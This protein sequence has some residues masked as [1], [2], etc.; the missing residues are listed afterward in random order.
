MRSG[1]GELSARR[2]KWGESD[3]TPS[4][5]PI[6]GHSETTVELAA[7]PVNAQVENPVTTNSIAKRTVNVSGTQKR[8]KCPAA[9]EVTYHLEVIVSP[10]E[11]I[12][13]LD[14]SYL[15]A[16][17]LSQRDSATD[18]YLRETPSSSDGVAQPPTERK[19]V[20][21]A[22]PSQ[23]S[24]AHEGVG[25]PGV[26]LSDQNTP[27]KAAAIVVFRS[28]TKLDSLNKGDYVA[29]NFKPN[30]LDATSQLQPVLACRAEG[31]VQDIKHTDARGLEIR[32]CL[33]LTFVRDGE[34]LSRSMDLLLTDPS[35]QPANS[36]FG[37]LQASGKPPAESMTRK[38]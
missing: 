37:V 36:H 16:S 19:P 13:L 9:L 22:A 35:P 20:S 14:S 26:V 27:M 4:T 28:P 17:D 24:A 31:V 18:A 8:F 32:V 30:P 3:S 25:S 10:A 29:A 12:T 5:S 38:E 6:Y 11:M 33:N 2:F 1:Y 15:M 21:D 7:S 34:T 23:T